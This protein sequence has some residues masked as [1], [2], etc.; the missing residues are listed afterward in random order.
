MARLGVLILSN[1]VRNE[2]SS[3]LH[4]LKESICDSFKESVLKNYVIYFMNEMVLNLLFFFD[5]D[6]TA[7]LLSGSYG[8]GPKQ[9]TL[10]TSQFGNI[11]K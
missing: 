7:D 9:E 1:F 2:L 11:N 10:A 5:R 8:E 4:Q 6:F 3:V